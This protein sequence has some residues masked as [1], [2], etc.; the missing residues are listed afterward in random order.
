MTM[1]SI[2]LLVAHVA[3]VATTIIGL[4]VGMVEVNPLA[5][6]IGMLGLYIAK[7]TAVSAMLLLAHLYR[8]LPITRP[9]LVIGV[10]LGAVP[11]VSNAVGIGAYWIR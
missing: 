4:S 1:L 7:A 2:L 10:V 5:R 3:D 11:S 8:D 6:V 9:V